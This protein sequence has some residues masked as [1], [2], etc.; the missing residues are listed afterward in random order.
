MTDEQAPRQKP[1]PKPKIPAIT[2]AP[3]AANVDIDRIIAK[4]LAGDPFADGTQAIPLK[5]AEK[6]DTYIGSGEV[7]PN[8]HYELVNRKGWIPLTI[9]DLPE[10][11][12]PQAIGWNVAEDGQT[13]CR[14]VRGQEVAYKMPKEV[15]SQIQA[16]KTRANLK[17]TGSATKVKEDVA[18]A[19]GGSLG[20]EAADWTQRNISITGGDRQGPLGA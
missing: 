16:A 11:V 2:V 5:D 9:A 3:R 18:N 6:W 17:G 20:S 13:L 19:V 1:G 8:R 10:G 14:G 15:R 7:N 12:T 4:R